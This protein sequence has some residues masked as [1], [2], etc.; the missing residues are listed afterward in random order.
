[1]SIL[2]IIPVFQET[3]KLFPVGRLREGKSNQSQSLTRTPG[4]SFPRSTSEASRVRASLRVT[5]LGT[6]S[7][8]FPTHA[9]S[10]SQGVAGSGGPRDERAKEHNPFEGMDT[11]RVT[12]DTQ[13]VDPA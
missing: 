8:T 3:G 2:I 13:T 7:G 1:M 11:G 12:E 10:A 5:R 9:G 6:A 4:G